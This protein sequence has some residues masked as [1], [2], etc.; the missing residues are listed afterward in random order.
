MIRLNNISFAHP[1][2]AFVLNVP[3]LHV[4]RGS[5]TAVVGP[6]GTGKTTLLNIVAGIH[7]PERG[8]VV[9]DETQISNLGDN[10]RRAFR[11]AHIGFVFQNFQLVEYLSARENILY[12]YRITNRLRLTKAVRERAEHLVESVGLADKLDRKPGALSQGEQQRIAICRALITQ[13]PLLLADE[14]TGNL[15]PENK[16]LILDLLFEQAVAANATLLAVTHD[17]ELLPRFDQVVDFNDFRM[18]SP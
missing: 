1:G 2:G 8:A 10:A 17:H 18:V 6:S 4:K 12:P 5:R 11:I 13:P 3:E 15:D 9:V 16:A 14:A 7:V